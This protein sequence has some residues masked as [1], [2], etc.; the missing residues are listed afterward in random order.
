MLNLSKVTSTLVEAPLFKQDL[1][2][3]PLSAVISSYET[4][5][6]FH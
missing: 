1:A 4:P 6:L 3:Q 5:S 2:E